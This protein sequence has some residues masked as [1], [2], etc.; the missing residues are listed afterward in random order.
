MSIQLAGAQGGLVLTGV[1]TSDI[2]VRI[3]LAASWDTTLMA[4]NGYL[5]DGRYITGSGLSY[6]TGVGTDSLRSDNSTIYLNGSEITLVSELHAAVSGDVLD[7]LMSGHQGSMTLFVNRSENNPTV[8]TTSSIQI[9]NA[10]G[11]TVLH[12]FDVDNINTSTHV[13]PDTVGTAVLSA[14][15]GGYTLF[16]PNQDPQLDT[17]NPDVS[18]QIGQ[19]GSIDFGSNFSDANVGD[20][21]TFSISPDITLQTG[22]T[23]NSSTGVASYDGTQEILAAADYTITA[24]DGNGGTDATDVVNIQVT[25]LALVVDTISDIT[26]DVGS[27]ITVDTSNALGLLTAGDFNIASQ[28]AGQVVIDIPNPTIFILS[29]Q[30]YPTLP[31]LADVD[32]PLSDGT[33]TANATVQIQP[34]AGWTYTEITD[35]HADGYYSEIQGLAVGMFAY[36]RVA[37]GDVIFDATD[38]RASSGTDGGSVE[39]RFYNGEWGTVGTISFTTDPDTGSPVG[40]PVGSY[41]TF[42]NVVTGTLSASIM[43]VYEAIVGGQTCT[44]TLDPD[45]L[46]NNSLTGR[47]YYSVTFSDGSKVQEFT[48][49]NFIYEFLTKVSGGKRLPGGTKKERVMYLT[50][51]LPASFSPVWLLP[52]ELT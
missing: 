7:I 16:A 2:I 13:I 10:A 27:Q 6:A 50:R 38:G 36:W 9:L 22:W 8:I 40:S 24:T 52:I 51:S 14:N 43:E 49:Y 44:V 41:T 25:P 19:I 32:I 33:N 11:D 48:Y 46:R 45:M 47:G 29:G 12:N 37:S 4:P 31:F 18:I 42:P 23:W 17:P 1:T 34:E 5:H 21:L 35:I 3:V 20:V 30:T 15:A 39:I 28:N 26:P